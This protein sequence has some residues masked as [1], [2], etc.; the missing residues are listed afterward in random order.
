[1]ALAFI[2]VGEVRKAFAQIIADQATPVGMER[3]FRYFASTYIGLTRDE[4]DNP[5]EE[6]FRPNLV[7]RRLSLQSNNSGSVYQFNF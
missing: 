7:P 5:A 3:Y 6:V 2:P 1:M 4:A